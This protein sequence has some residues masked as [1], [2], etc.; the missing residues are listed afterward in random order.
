MPIENPTA[1][2]K[3]VLDELFKFKIG[4]SVV[5]REQFLQVETDLELN[6]PHEN[7]YDRAK[8]GVAYM[9]LERHVQECHGGVQIGYSVRSFNNEGSAT[10]TRY[11]EYELVPYS[12]A[13]ELAKKLFP[14]KDA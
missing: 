9:I 12:E 13:V 3:P 7:R 8:P 11:F 14:K 6:G 10:I 5:L 2:M 4:D 1:K